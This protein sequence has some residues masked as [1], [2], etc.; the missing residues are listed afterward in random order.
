[1]GQQLLQSKPVKMMLVE[2]IFRSLQPSSWCQLHGTFFMRIQLLRYGTN[3]PCERPMDKTTKKFVIAACSVVIAMPVIIIG[4]AVI[5]AMQANN[6]RQEQNRISDRYRP[7]NTKWI[8]GATEHYN[9]TGEAFTA[10]AR[11]NWIRRCQKAEVPVAEF[12]YALFR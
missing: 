3:R 7:C 9:K 5:D 1:M 4:R 6:V 2:A 10:A 11:K 12:E 8:R